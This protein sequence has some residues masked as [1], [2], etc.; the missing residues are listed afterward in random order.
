MDELTAIEL[1]PEAKS[2]GGHQGRRRHTGD[3]IQAEF[4][5]AVHRNEN[6]ACC[7]AVL[8][9]MCPPP[10]NPKLILVATCMPSLST[11]LITSSADVQNSV[12]H[13]VCV[14]ARARVRMRACVC[15]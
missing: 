1:V 4:F 12:C 15:V 5:I 11:F 10:C 6:I 3:G 8:V 13:G 2:R 9:R 7:K 14:C